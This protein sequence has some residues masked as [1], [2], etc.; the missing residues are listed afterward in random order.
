METSAAASPLEAMAAPALAERGEPEEILT[1]DI[2]ASLYI[3]ASLFCWHLLC[4][5][6]WS[7]GNSQP[8]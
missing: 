5:V 6:N 8:N 3:I 1:R 7:S 2:I 4:L